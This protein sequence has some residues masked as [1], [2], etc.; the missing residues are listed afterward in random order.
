M[1]WEPTPKAPVTLDGSD[2]EEM[3]RNERIKLESQGLFHVQD[4]DGEPHTFRQELDALSIGEAPTISGTAKEVS[5]FFGIYKQEIR[6]ERGRK[7]GEHVFMVRIKNP[8]GGELTRRQW[9][10]LDEAADAFGDGTLRITSRQ[11]I[12]YHRVQGPR[13]APLIR[14]LNRHYRD[15]ATLGAC[16]DVNRN[17]M[18]SPIDGLDPEHDPRG[19]ELAR[20]IAHELAPRTGAYFQI[21]LSDDEGHQLTNLNPDEPLYGPHYLPRK[22]KIGIGH[23]SENS[24]DVL[25]NDIALVPVAD[26]G[27]GDGSL[28][29][30]HSGGGLGMTHNNPHTAPLLAL[31]LGRIRRDQ[32][33]EA[34]RAIVILQRDHGERRNRNAARWKYTIRRLGLARVKHELKCRFGVE[35]EEAAPQ[36]L[37][38]MR[39]HLGWHEQRGG[40]GFYGVS[41]ENGRLRPDLRRAVRRA[42][43][44]LE[45]GVRLTPQQDLLLCNVPERGALEAILREE[46]VAPP[47]TIALVRRNAMACP[48]KPTCG[49]AMTEAE[50]VLP[51]YIDALE[52]A[53]LGDLDAVIRMTGCPNNCARPPTAEI[54]IYGYGKNDH[55]ILVGG[56][57]EGTRLAHTLYA[58][59]PEEEMVPV[60]LGLFRAIREHNRE[61]L[62]VG[63]FLHRSDPEQLRRW[64]GIAGG[65]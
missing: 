45:L 44:E 60:L 18:C 30:L 12:Q 59:L 56:S 13:L 9:Q 50:N 43:E 15:Q 20:A 23:P 14:H 22:F 2:V 49:L 32:V 6:G 40:G 31:Y 38:P 8:A 34:V 57:R 63:E 11:G 54:G 3:S 42:L 10:A 47:E 39:L 4:S 52:E 21:F 35:L 46:G 62:P 27:A 29:D 24:V 33:L 1:A 36:A 55:V 65:E 41:V 17:V 16:G 5:K 48:A 28:W 19:R 37:A 51:R 25:T 58:R 64:I 53:G 61:D 26:G 7:T